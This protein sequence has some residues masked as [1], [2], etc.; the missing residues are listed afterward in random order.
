MAA[1]GEAKGGEYFGPTGF[2]E[3]KGPAG[4]ATYTSK[5]KDEAL[6]KKLW[7]VSENLVGYSY[8]SND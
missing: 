4:K 7:E 3:F 1:I 2:K 8:L 6:G 5:S